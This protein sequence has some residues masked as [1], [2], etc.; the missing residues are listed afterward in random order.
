MDI[1]LRYILRVRFSLNSS[2]LFFLFVDVVNKK[3]VE[4]EIVPFIMI[5]K[6]D[7]EIE[8]ERLGAKL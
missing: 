1:Y 7:E 3:R 4:L 5:K 6:C 2:F 8:K